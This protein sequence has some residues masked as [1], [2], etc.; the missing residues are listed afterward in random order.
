MSKRA[1][2]YLLLAA[3]LSFGAVI[4]YRWH[5]RT[6]TVERRA[7]RVVVRKAEREM[8]LFRGSH[9]IKTYHVALG[10]EPSGPK[11]Q[12]GDLKTPEGSYT[13]DHHKG[14]SAF[15]RA[16]HI[17][18][19][20]AQDSARAA[21]LGVAPGGDI[22]IHGLPNGLGEFGSVHRAIDWTS[23]CIAV[24]DSEIEE[25]WQAVPDGTRIEIV[26]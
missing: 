4:F 26:P 25:I 5:D 23:G 9:A 6:A 24:T 19:P 11:V 1:L 3:A 16:L 14:D 8:T 13:I 12:E 22:M 20:N 21:A 18:Y 15:H 10:R 7:D 2:L 17:S